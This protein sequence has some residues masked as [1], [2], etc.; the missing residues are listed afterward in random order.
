MEKIL[1]GIPFYLGR[2]NIPKGLDC[3]ILRVK[4]GLPA[5][6]TVIRVGL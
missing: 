3:F 1:E 2:V 5:V 4:V 6:I